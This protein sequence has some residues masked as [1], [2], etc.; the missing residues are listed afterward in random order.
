M[1]LLWWAKHAV[2]L[3]PKRWAQEIF[4]SLPHVT[5]H[6]LVKNDFNMIKKNM[7]RKGVDT[8]RSVFFAE[9]RDGRRIFNGFS[10][11]LILS[12][13]M[14][15]SGGKSVQTSYL[16][17]NRGLLFQMYI[18]FSSG[19]DSRTSRDWLGK[20]MIT[21]NDF[22]DLSD[23]IDTFDKS[24]WW[25][26]SGSGNFRR[27]ISSNSTGHMRKFKVSG[28][29][30]TTY[31]YRLSD[32][33]T[34][35]LLSY[36]PVPFLRRKMKKLFNTCLRTLTLKLSNKKMRTIL[37]YR[38]YNWGTFIPHHFPRWRQLFC[39][40]KSPSSLLWGCGSLH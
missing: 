6:P 22:R 2:L 23:Y 21:S 17:N 13:F 36:S 29:T 12:R 34:G 40:I 19:K 38:K 24:S 20:I 33:K 37:Y 10:P 27:T 16:M 1:I 15:R 5:P 39:H 30:K 11:E 7:T 28:N 3:N 26:C 8:I 31:S 32:V 9:L 18:A 4:Y 35:G 14:R 25:P